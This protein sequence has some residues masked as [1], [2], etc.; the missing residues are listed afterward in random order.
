MGVDL[1]RI[2]AHSIEEIELGVKAMKENSK[3]PMAGLLGLNP[4]PKGFRTMMGIDPTTA[5]KKMEE[6]GVDIV[7]VSCGGISYEET[8]A[9]LKEMKAACNK[10]LYAR[11]NA[12]VPQLVNGEVVHPG[13]P[14]E[15]SKEASNWVQTGA[16]LIAG[17][18]GTTPEHIARVV[19]VLK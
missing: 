19:A 16:K 5:A 6:L 2:P 7:G 9:A 4:T 13:T 12:G 8:T 3:L 17:C 14:E 1:I 10:H 11:P 18:C 15:M